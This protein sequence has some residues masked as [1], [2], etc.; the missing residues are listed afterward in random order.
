MLRN[1]FECKYVHLC[2]SLNDERC[3]EYGGR[4]SEDGPRAECYKKNSP[5]YR[6]FDWLTTHN[7]FK[8]NKK[9]TRKNSH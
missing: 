5:A 7:P 1:R 6:L 3:T 2:G 4:I 8:K 9:R